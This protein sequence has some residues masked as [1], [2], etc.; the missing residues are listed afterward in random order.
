MYFNKFILTL[1]LF[2]AFNV[3][4]VPYKLIAFAN[5]FWIFYYLITMITIIF[6]TASTTKNCHYT[7]DVIHHIIRSNRKTF[8]KEVIEKLSTFSLQV[9]M[10]N[11]SFS[12]GLFHFDWPLF[13]SVRCF[14]LLK[15]KSESKL[16]IFQILAAIAMY[17]VFLIQFDVSPTQDPVA[18]TTVI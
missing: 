8:S 18:L 11:N 13:A 1:R 2:R 5:G 14:Y 17:L 4:S 16:H 7:G 12:C 3:N 15:V 9:K 6:I 10:R